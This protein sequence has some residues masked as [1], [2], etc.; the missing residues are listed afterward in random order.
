MSTL[1]DAD[2]YAVVKLALACPTCRSAGLIP[3]EH[4]NR[5]LFCRGCA[6][7]FR[8]EPNG[9]FEVE[10]PLEER[11]A[12]QVRS[13]SS[14]WQNHRAVIAR[15]ATLQE[16]LRDAAIALAANR[17]AC[18]A[19]ALVLVGLIAGVVIFAPRAPEPTPPRELPLALAERAA[20]LAESLA[21]RDMQTL[22]A[23]TD[24]AQHRA[25]RIWLAHGKDL[26]RKLATD[27][28]IPESHVVRTAKITPGGETVDVRVRLRT[29]TDRQES[30][31]D[32]RW[33]KQGETWFFRPVRMRATAQ[34]IV[35]PATN[36]RQHSP[37]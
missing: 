17:L 15:A 20:L 30:V 27:D 23:L 2:R 4:L 31:L 37:R 11:I 36:Q 35:R 25:L 5:V 19:G 9:L 10:A 26:P 18:A 8:V 12:V 34:P 3:V 7:A 28:E 13:S 14:S 32:Q 21:T 33:V 24:P 22:I 16:R 1:P 6:S 29:P